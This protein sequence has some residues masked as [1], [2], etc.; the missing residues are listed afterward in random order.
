MIDIY[1]FKSTLCMFG[2]KS[3]MCVYNEIHI[4]TLQMT[5]K[6]QFLALI[7]CVSNYSGRISKHAFCKLEKKFNF[8]ISKKMSFLFIKTSQNQ[9]NI[10]T[11][12]V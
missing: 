5:Q 11:L 10:H 1:T 3:K 12:M 6:H 8:N 7:L 9:I 4:Q 2:S